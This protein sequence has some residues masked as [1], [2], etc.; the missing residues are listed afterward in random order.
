[1][2][3]CWRSTGSWVTRASVALVVA[4]TV[5][6][7][8]VPVRAEDLSGVVLEYQDKPGIWLSLESHRLILADLREVPQYRE[9]ISLLE[10][11]LT[12][13]DAQI[14][15]LRMSVELAVK[16]KD[17]VVGAVEEAVRGRR[18]AEER[19]DAWHRSR[20]LWF[21][22]GFVAALALT[23]GTVQLLNATK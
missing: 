11:K 18:E 7:V 19:L 9:R 3:K 4:L 23:Y 20:V 10:Q 21:G 5:I 8:S 16:A 22:V 6:L 12:L 15:D 13:Q 2:K 14:N 17:Q 1:M